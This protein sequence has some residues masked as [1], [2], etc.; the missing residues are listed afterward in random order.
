MRT[1]TDR[2]RKEFR[3]PVRKF[4][5]VTVALATMMLVAVLS[6]PFGSVGLWTLFA[7]AGLFQRQPETILVEIHGVD[8]LPPT[9]QIV[10]FSIMDSFGG[11]AGVGA[12]SDGSSLPV[13]SLP[14][15]WRR[16]DAM[17]VSWSVQNRTTCQTMDH[18]AAVP[19]PSYG[20]PEKM[21]LRFLDAGQVQIVLAN[22]TDSKEQVNDNLALVKKP[23]S[24]SVE[25]AM[26]EMIC[27]P[28]IAP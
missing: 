28:S 7:L 17:H 6:L 20:H 3:Y 24:S 16:G 14:A 9:Q 12:C 21:Y 19:L 25:P 15:Q 10:A 2:K 18:E 1:P 13:T 5:I 23:N 22:S 8:E 26:S 27:R 11:C 4:R